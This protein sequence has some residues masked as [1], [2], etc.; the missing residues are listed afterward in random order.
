MLLNRETKLARP[1]RAKTAKNTT[2]T[3]REI[4]GLATRASIG[5]TAA[6][7]EFLQDHER[8]AHGNDNVTTWRWKNHHSLRMRATVADLIRAL[9][10]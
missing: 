8:D 7:M 1:A 4:D 3:E 10:R 6:C 5:L 9:A 2:L